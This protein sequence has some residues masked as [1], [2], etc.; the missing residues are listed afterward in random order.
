MSRLDY[1]TVDV[2]I[3]DETFTLKPTLE[4][5]RQI[6]QAGLGGP[7]QAIKALQDFDADILAVVVAAGAGI[8]RKKV[9]DLAEKIHT[10]GTINVAPK[11]IEFV[12]KLI[13]PT[14]R[15]LDEVQPKDQPEGE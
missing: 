2:E 5:A 11:V 15:D 7:I 1:G 12:G 9:D 10:A 13:N 8:G 14:G 6:K 4:C 3:G